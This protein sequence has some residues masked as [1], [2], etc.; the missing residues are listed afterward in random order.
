MK[1]LN[2]KKTI[3]IIFT[4]SL[5]SC[6]PGGIEIKKKK[7]TDLEA[8]NDS[9]ASSNP[10]EDSKNPEEASNI[11]ENTDIKAGTCYGAYPSGAMPCSGSTSGLTE[12]IKNTFTS[13]QCGQEKCQYH[14]PVGTQ[15]RDNQC[16]PDRKSVV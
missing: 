15:L 8:S 2:L 11:N 12:N 6:V 16:L 7:N 9:E 4:L 3:L 13:A 5:I 10:E 14:C 1:I